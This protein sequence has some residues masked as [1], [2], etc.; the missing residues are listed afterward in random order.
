MRTQRTEPVG[1]GEN[2]LQV[3]SNPSANC[4]FIIWQ[5]CLSCEMLQPDCKEIPEKISNQLCTPHSG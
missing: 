3:F 4:F 2:N 1:H 5:T